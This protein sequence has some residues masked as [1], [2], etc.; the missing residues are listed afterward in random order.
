ANRRCTPLFHHAS[1]AMA[2]KDDLASLP[3]EAAESFRANDGRLIV[4]G[5]A[6]EFE[7][8]LPQEDGVHTY[9]SIKFP[10]FAPDGT[11]SA[12]CGMSTDITDR[13]RLERERIDLLERERAART[14]AESATRCKDQVRAGL[15]HELRTP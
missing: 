7:E 4:A 8:E 10:L 14:E 9:L 15:S 3:R 13:K 1:L 6:R 5:Q 12:V 2:R 11:I